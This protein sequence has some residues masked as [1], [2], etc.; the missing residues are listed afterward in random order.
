[1]KKILLLLIV[2]LI[3]GCDIKEFESPYKPNEERALINQVRG[4]VAMQ[5]KKEKNL[6]PCGFGGGAV[7]KISMLALSFNYYNE[8]DIEKARDLLVTAG[9]LFI[10]EVNDN[11]QIRPYLKNYPF[12]PTNIEIR[13][14]LRK[15][16]GAFCDPDTLHVV[17]MINGK[18]DYEIDNSITHLF[19]TIY[20][21]TF[22]EALAKHSE[23]PASAI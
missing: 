4:R 3:S 17:S 9:S 6:Y 23:K 22:E 1:M 2:V 12:E 18:L 10:K 14:F 5:L 7:D 13:I 15:P 21:E 8:I 20:S 19:E 11:E 16:N